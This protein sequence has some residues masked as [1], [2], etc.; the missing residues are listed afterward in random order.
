MEYETVIGLEVHAQL[1]T[2]TKIFCSCSTKFGQDPNSLTCPLCLGMPGV[3]PVLNKKVVE[4]TLKTALATNCRIQSYSQFA[5]KNYFYPDLPKGYQISQYELPIA[6]D[7]FIEIELE[8]GK[9]SKRIGIMRIHMEEDAGKLLHELDGV[10]SESSYVD[11]NRTGVPLMEIVS[12]PDITTP[13]EAGE[14]LRLLRSVLQYLEVCDGNME[15]G[16]FR[17]D[18]NI[19]LRPKGTDK[20]G[21]KVELKNMN[22]FRHVMRALEYEIQ[23]Q[24]EMLEDNGKIV[25]ETRLWDEGKGVSF[26]MRGKEEA[27]E[28]RYFPDPDLV[29]LVIEDSWVQEIRKKLPELPK[30]KVER[31]VKEYSIPEYDAKILATSRQLAD[32]FEECVK[33]YNRPKSISNWIMG[34]ILRN[35]GDTRDIVNFSI[36]P[37]HLA[38]MLMLIDKGTISGKIAKTV[39]QEMLSSG[40]MPETVVEEKGLVQVSDE[41]ELKKIIRE[42]LDA[43]EKMVEDYRKGKEKL[44]GFFVGQVMKATKG[45]A[46]PK[47][48]NEMLRKKL[49]G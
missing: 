7:G 43:N 37:K 27:H 2:K 5:R 6:T 1:L 46:N 39:F 33:L 9:R 41:G 3:L 40:K 35:L 25:Q 30:Q 15:Q 29:P 38:E 19:S 17:C 18:A 42:I 10:S 11:F 21:T 8:E 31:F 47:L 44:F 48:V 34:D 28:Y 32:Y 45:K 13:E 49:A 20:F 16:S 12:K 24:K 4:F 23:R 14:Y 26:S 22:S 36:T